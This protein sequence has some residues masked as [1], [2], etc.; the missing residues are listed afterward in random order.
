MWSVIRHNSIFFLFKITFIVFFF[1]FPP[2][3]NNNHFQQKLFSGISFF[4][5]AVF[6]ELKIDHRGLLLNFK[7]EIILINN[8]I[9]SNSQYNFVPEKNKVPRIAGLAPL[10]K[11][12]TKSQD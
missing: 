10:S 4:L 9:N 5:I 2:S 6:G 7:P 12:I 11:F 1:S 8:Q 3:Q